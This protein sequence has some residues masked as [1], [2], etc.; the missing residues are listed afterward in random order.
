MDETSVRGLLE[1]ALGQEPPVKPVARDALR[2]GIR[3]R[4]RVRIQRVAGA[5]AAVVVVTAVIPA[6][7][8]AFGNTSAGP[9]Q[10]TLPKAPTGTA[11]V[12]NSGGQTV[13]PIDLATNTPGKPIPA[14]GEIVA[15]AITPDGKTA[16]VA[17][18]L[19]TASST[20]GVQPIDLTTGTPGKP[21]PLTNPSDAIVITP[22][23]KTAYVFNGF[24]S[25]T[26]T[27][28][29][30]ATSTPGQPITLA[31][32]PDAIAMAPD[33]KTA[34]VGIESATTTG[35]QVQYDFAPFDLATNKLGKPVKL[36][37]GQPAAISIAPDGKTAYVLSQSSST[38]V[39][40]TPIDLTT[41][42]AENPVDFSANPGPATSYLGQP[43]AIAISPD[44]ATA[45]VADGA[46]STVTPI[47]LATNTPGKAIS[48]S[49][50]RGAD[51]IAISTNGATAYVANEPTSTVTPIDLTTD[52]PEKPIKL[53]PGEDTGIAAIVTVP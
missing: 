18:G 42:T 43:L 48:L 35:S 10:E 33:G 41:D 44:G 8:G 7:T 32:P 27:P 34:Y 23:G 14:D 25:R 5:A 16:Y 1:T 47:D 29:D 31:N 51:A 46:S 17:T 50:K 13:T 4:R 20:Q 37:S 36:S 19:S 15:I 39:T 38:V 9:R 26:V 52:R 2:A 40:V 53:A 30:L 45:Y 24:P 3:M 11:Y 28:I 12:I 49:G 21:I 6:V 22:D